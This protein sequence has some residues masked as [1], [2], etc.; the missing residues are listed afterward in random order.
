M[1]G[2]R[3]RRV[4]ASKS[5]RMHASWRDAAHNHYKSSVTSQLAIAAASELY[6]DVIHSCSSASHS[7]NLSS[8]S[9]SNSFHNVNMGPL[10]QVRAVLL[11]AR[12][13]L[14][15]KGCQLTTYL[16][17]HHPETPVSPMDAS[18]ADHSCQQEITQ[19][20]SLPEQ[21]L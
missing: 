8:H 20:R 11:H 10:E 12:C 13:Q 1:G 9:M 4:W 2:S 14:H 15:H 16:I 18:H 21:M 5:V 3:T 17:H 6:T 19:A 7:L